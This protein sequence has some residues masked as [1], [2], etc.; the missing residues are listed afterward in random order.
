MSRTKDMVMDRMEADDSYDGE[1]WLR[2]LNDEPQP[3]PISKG[4]LAPMTPALNQLEHLA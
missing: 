2:D 1:G 3:E 4:S